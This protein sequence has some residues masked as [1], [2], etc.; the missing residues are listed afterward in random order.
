MWRKDH[1]MEAS[2]KLEELE[3]EDAKET[4]ERR[5]LELRAKGG[6][7]NTR[8]ANNAVTEGLD[9][10][11][12]HTDRVGTYVAEQRMWAEGCVKVHQF[13]APLLDLRSYLL[14]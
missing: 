11:T 1:L 14:T 2:D 5:I 13:E 3:A 12:P 6:G 8:R 9:L 4:D 7:R 10:N